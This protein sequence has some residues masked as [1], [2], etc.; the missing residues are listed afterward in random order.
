[1]TITNETVSF[2][3]EVPAS[4]VMTE[5]VVLGALGGSIGLVS[6]SACYEGES[7]V[8]LYFQKD[9]TDEEI[10]LSTHGDKT[11]NLQRE[12]SGEEYAG[13]KITIELSNNSSQQRL[14]SASV[15]VLHYEP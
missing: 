1:M 10:I 2:A 7:H 12:W 8:A 6:L 4:G 5:E 11:I 9:Q 3:K 14:L 13:K 15:E